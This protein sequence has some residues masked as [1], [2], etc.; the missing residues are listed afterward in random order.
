[1]A[2]EAPP[3]PLRHPLVAMVLDYPDI[4]GQEFPVNVIPIYRKTPQLPT[5]SR[6][7]Q[8]AWSFLI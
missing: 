2:P 7:A 4:I 8:W 5:R 1:M 3:P 6:L